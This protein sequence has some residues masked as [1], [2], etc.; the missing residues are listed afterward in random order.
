[1]SPYRRQDGASY[2]VDVRWRGFPRVK[3][4]TDTPNKSRAIAMER[5]LHALRS[6][7]R[8]DI[9]EMLADGRQRL[10]DVHDAYT[11]D[12][13]ALEQLAAKSAS[14]ALGPLVDEFLAWLASP[15]G[16]SRKTR[17]RFA[18]GTVVRYGVSWDRLFA[19]LPQGR[20]SQLKDVTRGF[21]ADFRVSRDGASASTVNRDLCALAAFYTWASEERGLVAVRPP[22]LREKEPPGLDRW[23]SP[24]E[25]RA[26]EAKCP[27]F[28]WPLY[29]TLIYTG[30]RVGEAQGLVGGEVRLAERRIAVR[31]RTGRRLKTESS[32]RDVPI[33][34]PLAV[35]LGQHFARFPASPT[36]PVFPWPLNRYQAAARRFKSVCEA[37]ELHGVTIHTLRH[38]FGVHLAQA[39]VPIPRIQKLMGHATPAMSLRYAAHSP[40]SYFT[41][42]AA[43]LAA[44]IQGADREAEARAKAA[45]TGL[46]TA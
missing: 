6:A 34:E 8:R 16:V 43:A 19:V 9:L 38:T 30:L 37:A 11:K 40:A 45:Q 26:L 32:N 13:A 31:D 28:W 20:D 27:A 29:A 14:P 21:V 17:R 35:V 33:P 18:P 4:S 36:A 12:P 39:N 15:A 46:R 44:N 42:D 22:L 24:D 10:A 7:G 23:L 25:I 41:E 2:Y 3:L 5:T 1:M